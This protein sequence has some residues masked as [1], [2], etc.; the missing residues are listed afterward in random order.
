MLSDE[1]LI[2][3]V[4]PVADIVARA[5]EKALAEQAATHAI[6]LRAYEATVEN[7]QQRI[8]ELDAQ[9]ADSR[10]REGRM[11]ALLDKARRAMAWNI[12]NH[13]A[14]VSAA[15][16]EEFDRSLATLAAAPAPKEGE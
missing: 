11:R 1:K 15:L 13:D 16:Y 5:V 14:K 6:E 8:R 3:P 4:D 9:L 12:S 10:E 7:L 2:K